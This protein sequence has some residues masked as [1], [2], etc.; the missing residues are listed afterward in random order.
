MIFYIFRGGFY[1]VIFFLW[2]NFQYAFIVPNIL[3]A[4]YFFLFIYHI[5]YTLNIIFPP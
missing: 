4:F 2:P 1:Y 3:F 5:V